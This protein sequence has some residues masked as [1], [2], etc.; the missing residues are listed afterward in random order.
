[1]KLLLVSRQHLTREALACFLRQSA[2]GITVGEASDLA[3]GVAA[4]AEE[5]DLI[6]IDRTI[7]SA[8]VGT[9][10]LR[11]LAHMIDHAGGAR[12][13]LLCA[14]VSRETLG[15][16][17]RLGAAGVIV[18]DL[19][20][21]ALVS[22]LRLILVGETYVPSA[23]LD[24]PSGAVEPVAAGAMAGAEA[25]SKL[26]RRELEAIRQL[27]EGLSN[28]EIAQRL[29]LAEVTVKLHLHNAFEK[30]GA[31]S[32]ADAVRIALVRGLAPVVPQF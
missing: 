30:I 19:R 23:G 29:G 16:A 2:E 4:A 1:M 7:A 24:E 17:L 9:G 31:R 25:A 15:E 28:R 21:S 26:T 3:E 27:A 10:D 12:V 22:A 8:G 14:E 13:V 11:G 20:G 18:T 32:R 5:F 6:L